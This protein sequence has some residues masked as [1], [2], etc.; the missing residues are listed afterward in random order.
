[1][2]VLTESEEHDVVG[3][4]ANFEFAD[5]RM[6][7]IVAKRRVAHFGV[8]YGYDSWKLTPAPPMPVCLAPLR[9]R[10]AVLAGIPPKDFA[11]V[12]V[13]RYETGSVI[14]WHRDAP[15]FGPAVVGISLHGDCK[16]RFRKQVGTGWER[17]TMTLGRR[18]AYILAGSARAEWQHSIPPVTSLRYSVT[19]RTLKRTM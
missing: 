6:H 17:F 11:E 7:G 19:F 10:A 1:A 9:D 3:E 14:G 12:L 8:R 4:V 16:M 5:V 13:T 15:Q 2:D 18:S